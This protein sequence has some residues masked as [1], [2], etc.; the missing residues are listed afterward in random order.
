MLRT[1]K[2]M[3]HMTDSFIFLFSQT[4][5]LWCIQIHGLF[6]LFDVDNDDRVS[7]DDFISCLR[8]HPLLIALFAP[9]LLHRGSSIADQNLV[10]EVL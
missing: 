1:N 4:C 6:R 10:E 2:E 5:L 3:S 9:K 7:R 8:R